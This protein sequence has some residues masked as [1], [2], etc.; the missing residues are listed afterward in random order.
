M[1]YENIAGAAQILAM[2]IFGFVMAGFLVYA[3]RPGNKAKFERAARAPLLSDEESERDP[4]KGHRS[5]GHLID[6]TD[7]GEAGNGRA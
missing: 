2:I 6:E 3:L 1:T 5:A 7:N 4:D